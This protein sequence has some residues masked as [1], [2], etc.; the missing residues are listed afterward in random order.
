MPKIL[1]KVKNAEKKTVKNL[2]SFMGFVHL[3]VFRAEFGFHGFSF[4]VVHRVKFKK[5]K[6]NKSS[7]NQ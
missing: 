3:W 1:V 5:R 6:Q 7:K 2:S 4:H